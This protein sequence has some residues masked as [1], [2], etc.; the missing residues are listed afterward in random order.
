VKS[1]FALVSYYLNAFINGEANRTLDHVNY[2]KVDD[3]AI[4][5][6]ANFLKAC[7]KN[8]SFFDHKNNKCINFHEPFFETKH[9]TT[10]GFS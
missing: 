2:T 10:V 7:Q 8:Q 3:K 9:A 5:D 4:S 6:V 1:A